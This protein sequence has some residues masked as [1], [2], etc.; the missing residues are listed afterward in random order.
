MKRI[1]QSVILGFILI[2]KSLFG[3]YE[4]DV[5]SLFD[6]K[7]TFVQ[8]ENK[9]YYYFK[10]LLNQS[11]TDAAGAIVNLKLEDE[12]VRKKFY[13]NIIR[14]LV[15]ES[16]VL[17]MENSTLKILN[18]LKEIGNIQFN[19]ASAATTTVVTLLEFI[20]D[21]NNKNIYRYLRSNLLGWH[22]NSTFK[23]VKARLDKLN[24]VLGN[25]ETITGITNGSFTISQNAI[26]TLIINSLYKG[27]MMDKIE[28][29]QTNNSEIDPLIT[30]VLNELLVSFE[31]EDDLII[32]SWIDMMKSNTLTVF[33]FSE[34][35][36]IYFPIKLGAGK[37]SIPTILV[38]E[39]INELIDTFD[40]NPFLLN[41]HIAISS[42]L[43]NNFGGTEIFHI[44][45][46]NNMFSE[47]YI[48]EPEENQINKLKIFLL[49]MFFKNLNEITSETGWVEMITSYI[50]GENFNREDTETIS[51]NMYN[52]LIRRFN[53]VIVVFADVSLE[54]EYFIPVKYLYDN[55][56][57]EYKNGNFYPN[58]NITR[59]QILKIILTMKKNKPEIC[60]TQNHKDNEQS[61]N[62]KFTD[63]HSSNWFAEYIWCA[64]DINITSGYTSTDNI[65]SFAPE[66]NVIRAEAYKF[67]SM[68]LNPPN[69]YKEP[70]NENWYD[71]YRDQFE[72]Y[73]SD[74]LLRDN[75]VNNDLT[76]GEATQL[77]YGVCMK[78]D[79]FL[80]K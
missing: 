62:H 78:E 71:E 53:N 22:K 44:D 5:K 46:L 39:A 8:R 25:F 34:N 72:N 2:Q 41:Q 31:N 36:D 6:I 79:N 57:I 15:I 43:I 65:V 40:R 26:Q 76:R 12:E 64:S 20:S 67:I 63:V 47:K 74:N 18:E 60:S 7:L 58:D 80:C 42:L 16:T 14:S 56:A 45:N 70:L 21:V 24:N 37:A 32:Q 73:V 59:A 52:N 61:Y 54:S 3:Y 77:I 11:R 51:Q 30:E 35:S 27:I 48:D 10:E 75:L 49:S 28:L 9:P 69:D 23:N 50:D 17:E 29:L 55:Q 68:G 66:K 1:I 4:T 13:K 38:T 19:S 33:D